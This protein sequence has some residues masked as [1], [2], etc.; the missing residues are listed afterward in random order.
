[1]TTTSHPHP[2]TD[3]NGRIMFRCSACDEPLTTDDF[4]DLG[5]RFPDDGETQD[6]YFTAELLDGLKHTDC[7][8]AL[9]A[10]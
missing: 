1:M 10:G 5:L 9:A 6:D 3:R 4:F 7:S 8:R 2:I